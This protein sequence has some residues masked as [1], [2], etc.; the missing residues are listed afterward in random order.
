MKALG[1]EKMK[2]HTSET[3]ADTCPYEKTHHSC[4]VKECEEC[5]VLTEFCRNP[6][7]SPVRQLKKRTET[8]M[9]SSDPNEIQLV[10]Q[11]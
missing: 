4:E 10:S 9:V 8:V 1:L 6:Q 5:A 7:R 2:R 3:F 11:L